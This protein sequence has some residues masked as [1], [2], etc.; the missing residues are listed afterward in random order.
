MKKDE[1]DNQMN[2]ILGSERENDIH[3]E[4]D[5][6][7]KSQGIELISKWKK[8]NQDSIHNIKLIDKS[9]KGYFPHL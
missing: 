3:K 9:Y 4:K 7:A 8:N 6:Y 2:P 1:I 5:K